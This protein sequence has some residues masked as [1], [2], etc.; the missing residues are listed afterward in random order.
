VVE[1]TQKERVENE[2][3]ETWAIVEIMGRQRFAGLCTEQT[4]AGASMLR[5]DVP[6]TKKQGAFTKLFGSGAIHSLTPTTQ[7]IACAL[8]ER[9]DQAPI[10]AYEL[11]QLAQQRRLTSSFLETDDDDDDEPEYDPDMDEDL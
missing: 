1:S 6:A 7:E 11:P 3:F 8:A 10:Q 9:L 2:K 4:L 5:I